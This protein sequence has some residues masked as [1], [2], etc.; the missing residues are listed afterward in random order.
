M[1]KS[2]RGAVAEL[3]FEILWPF[4]SNR[5]DITR[6]LADV[7]E[8]GKGFYFWNTRR[9]W[10]KSGLDR[11][12]VIFLVGYQVPAGHCPWYLLRAL[13]APS[14]DTDTIFPWEHL[15]PTS[16]QRWP[17]IGIGWHLEAVMAL[18]YSS[19]SPPS[20][21]PTFVMIRSTVIMI[22]LTAM[23]MET[24][25][26]CGLTQRKRPES[27]CL[28]KYQGQYCNDVNSF[29]DFYDNDPND[30]ENKTIKDVGISLLTI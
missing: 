12:L 16:T 23:I 28:S 10:K 14:C 21:L 5:Y 1:E 24:R 22:T 15:T 13:G 6:I 8:M 17:G 3:M 2:W 4:Q 7:P 19:T 25:I 27:S 11:E 29:S 30:D 9:F 18:L 26:T 20:Q